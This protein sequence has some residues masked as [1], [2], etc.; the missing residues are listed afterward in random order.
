[1]SRRAKDSEIEYRIRDEATVDAYGP[2]EQAIGWYYYL[3]DKLHAPFQAECRLL[4]K[5]SPLLPGEVVTVK[6]MAGA[7]ECEKEI[8]VTVGWQ[9][10]ELAV[11]LIQLKPLETDDETLEAV[12]DWHYWM[13][14]GYEF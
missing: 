7:D 6:E 4:R 3:D 1:M 8:F 5:T 14:R 12:G 2:E 10:R 11:P 9:G 13:E